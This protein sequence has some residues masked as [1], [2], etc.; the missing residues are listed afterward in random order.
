M[1]NIRSFVLLLFSLVVL[2][3]S[4][5]DAGNFSL[6][7]RNVEQRDSSLFVV[8]AVPTI[9]SLPIYLAAHKGW[10]AADSVKVVVDTYNSQM[11]CDTAVLGQSAHLATTDM[12]R[13]EYY[14]SRGQYLCYACPTQ[15]MW[16][17]IVNGKSRINKV[18]DLEMKMVGVDRFSNSDYLC[19]QTLQK[20]GKEYNFVFRPQ[21]NDYVLRADMMHTQD[22][23]AAVLPEPYLSQ[24]L[25]KG[26][27][28]LHSPDSLD[29]MLG[30]LVVNP[31]ILRN[32]EK[33]KQLRYVFR[34]YN[35]AVD[36]LN[37]RGKSICNEVLKKHYEVNDSTIKRI[38]L[39]HYERARLVTEEER[40]K[41]RAFN[42][43]R[44]VSAGSSPLMNGINNLN[45]F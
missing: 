12:F 15:G 17:F 44:G 9:E 45:L 24:S 3:L 36:S 8:A 30:C 16:A 41:A 32:S 29:S 26:H 22:F 31:K 5:D 13:V 1:K 10:F 28:V 40:A 25:C 37:L 42:A 20:A 7:K 27:K 39:P 4:C 11:D 43:K 23:P 35:Q 14:A 19:A 38:K 33:L 34:I 6:S 2:V 21:I 18:A